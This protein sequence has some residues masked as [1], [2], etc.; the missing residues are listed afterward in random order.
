[1]SLFYSLCFYYW[2][3][4]FCLFCFPSL[5]VFLC[6]TCMLC[7]ISSTIWSRNSLCLSLQSQVD[8]A[9][10]LGYDPHWD[11]D[12]SSS[13]YLQCQV[14]L[15]MICHPQIS[16]VA[17]LQ[18]VCGSTGWILTLSPF[19]NVPMSLASVIVGYFFCSFSIW[20][21]LVCFISGCRRLSLM[22][23][24]VWVL[25]LSSLWAGLTF[26]PCEGVLRWSSIAK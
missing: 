13:E 24:R 7:V 12:D 20:P 1:M 9:L 22:G 16:A 17:F 5:S 14:E 23:R 15:G 11:G 10:W 21:W 19:L 26:F 8:F 18:N 2:Q 6:I 4:L 3:W 25:L